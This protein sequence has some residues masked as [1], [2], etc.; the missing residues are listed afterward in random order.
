[1]LYHIPQFS[2]VPISHEVIARLLAAYPNTVTGI[3]DSAG[4]IE[5]MVAMVERFPGFSVLAGAD[6]LLLPL[7]RAGGAGC[8][9]ATS[10]L[11]AR[12]LAFIAAHFNDATKAEEVD[13]AQ[14]RVVATR[15]RASKFA[16]IASLKAMT[17]ERTALPG[18]RRMR[19][20]LLSLTEAELAA[21]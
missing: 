15:N 21:L 18:W 14:A 6:P 1:M 16:Q 13:A 5:N 3:K 9:T 8:I 19:P 7:L 17:A 12:D 10:N 11:V 20:P 2:A 4:K